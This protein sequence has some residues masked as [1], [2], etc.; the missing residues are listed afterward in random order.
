MS[1]TLTKPRYLLAAAFLLAGTIH[2]D[3][4]LLKDGDRI[5]GAIVKKD[6]DKLTVE[7]KSFGVVTVKWNDIESIR[8]EK[9]LT[10]VLE[11]D[12]TEK[13]TI[14]TED[15]KLRLGD[16]EPPTVVAPSGVL[17]L[18]NEVEQ[19]NYEKLLRPGIL[20]LWT[21]TGSL[22]IAGASGNAGTSTLTLPVNFVRS[23]RTS[24][25]TAYF[26]AIRSTALVEGVRSQT[27]RAVRGGW[28]FSRNV[29]TRAFLSA[30]NDWEYDK[31]QS[32]DLRT[33]AGGGAGY[34]V[35]KRD[36][37]TLGLV[38]GVAWNREA[39]TPRAAAAFTRHSAEAY[40]GND[41]N[42][43]VSSRTS[44]VHSLRMFNSLS[45][46][47]EYRINFDLGAK[48]SIS[49][50]LTWDVSVTDRF[51]SNPVSGRKRNDLLYSTGIGFFFSR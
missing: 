9:P 36:A 26:N 10:V 15:G 25:T 44:L 41:W 49:K 4:I 38:A 22:N 47:G 51:L 45:N 18:R 20:D 14:R 30:F 6:G 5:T 7:S 31:F 8:A 43:K 24:R 28:T 19:R 42:Y 34:Q 12:R 40:W 2:A 16:S 13:T 37:G 50:W 27:A 21:V 3:Q 46:A 17:A 33:V 32:L 11:G 48:T 39:F 29:T 35:W 23:S 1:I